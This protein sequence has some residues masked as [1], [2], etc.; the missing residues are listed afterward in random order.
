VAGSLVRWPGGGPGAEFGVVTEAPAGANRIRVE[1]PA[2]FLFFSRAADSLKRVEFAVGAL[3]RVLADGSIGRVGGRTEAEG[4]LTYRITFADGSSRLVIEADLRFEHAAREAEPVVAER[5]RPEA[6]SRARAARESKE[7]R[8]KAHA[9]AAAEA[10]LVAAVAAHARAERRAAALRRIHQTFESDFLGAD[11]VYA[12]MGNAGINSVEYAALKSSVVKNWARKELRDTLDDEQAAA[13]AT[14]GGDVKVVAR[15]GSGKTRTL[16]T[17]AIFLQRHCGVSPQELLLLAFNSKAA[18]EMKERLRAALGND[19]PHTMTFHAL[20]WAIV[21]PEEG[22]LID[23]R[24]ADQPGLSREIREVID[25]HIRSN[26]HHDRVRDLM[27][28]YFRDDWERIFDRRNESTIAEFRAIRRSLPRESLRGDYVKSFGER[29]IAN[30]LFD[31]D[32]PYHYERNHRWSGTNY[33]PD[34]TV[35]RPDGGVI[36]EYFG[37]EGDPD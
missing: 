6:V 2:G 22:L 1:F 29:E 3:V 11:A 24:A 13:V 23:D 15:A 33:R 36:I 30:A 37:L 21:H 19:I 25:E 5:Q 20:A 18:A 8:E 35:V 17:R 10:R 14:Q 28:A 9:V 31:H 26:E 32:V 27:L 16:V 34:F 4:L 7:R 12:D